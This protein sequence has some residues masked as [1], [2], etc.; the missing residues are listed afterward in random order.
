MQLSGVPDH[1]VAD[2]HLCAAA[3]VPWQILRRPQRHVDSTGASDDSDRFESICCVGTS[4]VTPRAARLPQAAQ[5]RGDMLWLFWQRRIEYGDLVVGGAATHRDHRDTR[6]LFGW[7]HH[8]RD[9]VQG[10]VDDAAG[11]VARQRFEQTG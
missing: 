9:R 2:E 4:P 8:L 7:L 3:G 10:D 1:R 6:G 5:H 11:D